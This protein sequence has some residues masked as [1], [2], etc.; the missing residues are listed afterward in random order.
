MIFFQ[1]TR[2]VQKLDLLFP[3]I[4]HHASISLFLHSTLWFVK[5]HTIVFQHV[6][7][8]SVYTALVGI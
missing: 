1:S 7:F 3:I 4:F 6:T 8:P 2:K 5:L